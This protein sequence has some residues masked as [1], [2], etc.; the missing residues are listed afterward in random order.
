MIDDSVSTTIDFTAT[1]YSD[2]PKITERIDCNSV[3]VERPDRLEDMHIAYGSDLKVVQRIDTLKDSQGNE[4]ADECYPEYEIEYLSLHTYLKL[5]RRA[6]RIVLRTPSVKQQS[7]ISYDTPEEATLVIKDKESGK[8]LFRQ[9]F[10]VCITQP[11][12][13]NLQIVHTDVYNIYG[14]IFENM[15]I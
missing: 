10:H 1:L 6:D 3:T 9:S 7:L 12:C 11:V 4:V 13:K 15:R 5:S 2:D 8:T 14:N